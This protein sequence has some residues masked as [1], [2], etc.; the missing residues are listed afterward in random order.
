MKHETLIKETIECPHCGYEQK[1][2][3]NVTRTQPD[4]RLRCVNHK[5]IKAIVFKDR[6]VLKVHDNPVPDWEE[7]NK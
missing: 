1:T 7:N 3:Y 5:C 4:D 2:I 6:I